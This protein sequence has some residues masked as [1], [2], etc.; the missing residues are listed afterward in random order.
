MPLISE[1]N[2]ESEKISPSSVIIIHPGSLNLRIGCASDV[3]PHTVIHGIARAQKIQGNDRKD[4]ILTSLPR[5]NSDTL[6]TMEESRL[7]ASHMLQSSLQSNGDRRYAT[8]PQQIASYNRKSVPKHLDI[9]PKQYIKPTSDTVFG[10][11]IFNIDPSLN[12]NIYFPIVNGDL[13]V[14][15]KIGGSL[16]AV[17]SD[18][19]AIW[20]F[21]INNLLNVPTS[22]FKVRIFFNLFS[23]ILCSTIRRDKE[24]Y[25]FL[26]NNS[27]IFK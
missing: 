17:L 27:D 8:P 1:N 23:I 18:L 16:T 26:I 2:S 7:Q 4:Q 10:D 11:D 9:P 22:N 19:E 21:Y 13:N 25:A 15:G 5:K 6:A 24:I 12:Y 14:T 3:T 20:T